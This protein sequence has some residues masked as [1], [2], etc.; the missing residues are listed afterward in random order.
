MPLDIELETIV[1]KQIT[2]GT[3]FVKRC[4]RCFNF[5]TDEESTAEFNCHFH[6]GKFIDPEKEVISSHAYIASFPG[7]SCCNLSKV[8]DPSVEP[9]KY[10]GRG[11]K[12]TS[13]YIFLSF[14]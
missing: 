9:M 13:N 11:C 6:T 14:W 8:I 2:E 1:S 3:N 4:K 10:H 12:K 7:W 5:Y